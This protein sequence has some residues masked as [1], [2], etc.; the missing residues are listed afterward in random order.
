MQIDWAVV[1]A[2]IAGPILAVWA[3]E[4]RASA[5]GRFKTV[6]NGCSAPFGQPD[7]QIFIRLML[8]R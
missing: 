8:R 4:W 6:R 5:E 1:F 7:L 3:A 2:T